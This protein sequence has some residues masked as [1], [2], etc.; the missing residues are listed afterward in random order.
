MS[1]S[2][3]SKR[4]HHSLSGIRETDLALEVLPSTSSLDLKSQKL[5]KKEKAALDYASYFPE[6]LIILLSTHGEICVDEK[7]LDYSEVFDIP[8][9]LQY[10]SKL[11]IAP[12]GLSS[13]ISTVDIRD[14]EEGFKKHDLLK[15][16]EG[17]YN[18][19]DLT[20]FDNM[21]QRLLKNDEYNGEIDEQENT[22]V[23]IDFMKT[24]QTDF[25]D[26]YR[27]DFAEVNPDYEKEIKS[28]H[29]AVSL[30][31][32]M[33]MKLPETRELDKFLKK[34]AK[35]NVFPHLFSKGV[36]KVMANKRYSTS[37]PAHERSVDPIDYG[38]IGLNMKSGK[39]YHNLLP[40]ILVSM[41]KRSR[42]N[43]SSLQLKTSDVLHFIS[44]IKK[45]DG[46]PAVKRLMMIDLSCSVFQGENP[47]YERILTKYTEPFGWGIRKSKKT[48]K[49]RNK[50][51]RRRTKKNRKPKK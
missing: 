17:V 39:K 40:D 18:R 8:D 43:Y 47:K 19:T 35:H 22:R 3:S 1:V 31:Y 37:F 13:I 4:E 2:S 20:K 9:S 41:G 33:N 7:H 42:S 25:S 36:Q 10:V 5:T 29:K 28:L 48:N 45:A 49:S 21:V 27:E 30:H 34:E 51:N 12:A 44:N 11:N 6:N 23:L 14:V 16:L 24:L 15:H 26:Y 38:I 32:Y 46:S 50:K